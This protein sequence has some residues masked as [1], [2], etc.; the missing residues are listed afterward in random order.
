M[1]GHFV[2]EKRRLRATEEPILKPLVDLSKAPVFPP[3]IWSYLLVS[4]RVIY[5]AHQQQT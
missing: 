2:C 3:L 4:C 1:T 5:L